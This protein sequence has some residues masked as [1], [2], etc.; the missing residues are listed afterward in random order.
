MTAPPN[1]TF[2]RQ[3]AR[4]LRFTLGRPRSFSVSD[5]GSTV[6]FVRSASASDRVGRLWRW[7]AEDGEVQLVD[8]TVLLSGAGE[9]LS[10]EERARRERAR[11]S[12]AGIVGYSVDTSLTRVVFAL[13]GRLFV[14]EVSKPDST[15]EIAVG[16]T[17]VDPQIDPTGQRIA[18]LAGRGLHVVDLAEAVAQQLSPDEGETVSWGMADFIAAEELDRSRGFWWSPNGRQLLVQ[19]TDESPV[20]T[21]FVGNPATPEA[22]PVAQRYPAAGTPNAHMSLWL[23]TL[24]AQATEIDLPEDSE[25]L[26]TVHWSDRGLPVAAVL[27]RSQQSLRWYDI[28]AASGSTRLLRTVNDPC[29]VDVVPG[30][31]GW[32]AQGRLITVEVRDD[33]YALCVDGNR[34]SPPG[35]QVRSVVGQARSHL[36]VLASAEPGDQQVWTMG[37]TSAETVSP[38]RGW[39]VSVE[40]ADTRVLVHADLDHPHPR[41]TIEGANGAHEVVSHAARPLI[42]PRVTLLS[43]D[44]DQPRVALLLPSG[45]SPSDGSLPVLMDPYGGPHHVSV[46]HHQARLP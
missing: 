15:R 26:A 35:V 41:V 31:G 38:E 14:T 18:F 4:T 24:D 25:Y 8:P 20:N 13:S 7:T 29:W 16:R 44:R 19:R 10:H 43:G 46:A 30:T 23:L 5:D 42:D 11:E 21:W 45:W 12:A 40:G 27:D 34:I 32:D 6:V 1:D 9:D 2:P 33:D 37:D 22:E 36:T 28:D 3:N 39:A 17:V